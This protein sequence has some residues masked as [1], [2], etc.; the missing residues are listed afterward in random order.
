MKTCRAKLGVLVLVAWSASALAAERTKLPFDTY[1]GYFVSNKFEPDAA[2]SFVVLNDQEQ[3]DKAF[4]VAFVMGDKSHRL[5]KDAFK[6]LMVVAAI[7][8]GA[9]VVEYKVE[10]VTEANGVVEL[11]YTTTSKKSDSATFA[12]PLIV[13][14]PKGKH[15]AV[16]FVENGKPVKKLALAGAQGKAE[17]QQREVFFS[18]HVQGVGFRSTVGTLARGY[19][20]TGF[21]KNLRDGRVQLVVEGQPKEIEAFL[22]AIR[23]ERDKYIKNTEETTMPATGEF[24]KFEIRWSTR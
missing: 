1:S 9:A 24:D 23:K 22:A 3:F 8:R 5:P 10:A 15:S 12:C 18:G 11:H 20:V 16:E 14:I 21:V 2:E 7:K 19:T 6:S 13:S 4:G 17:A